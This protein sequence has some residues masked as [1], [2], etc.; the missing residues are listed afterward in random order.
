MVTPFHETGKAAREEGL[1]KKLNIM[2]ERTFGDP[3]HNDK[4]EFGQTSPEM[5][6]PECK[7]EGGQHDI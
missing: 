4:E 6:G 3:N 1:R 2:S 5:I 7:C